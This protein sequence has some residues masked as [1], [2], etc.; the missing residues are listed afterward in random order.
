MGSLTVAHCTPD[1]KDCKDPATMATYL[2]KKVKLNGVFK[3]FQKE[4][5]INEKWIVVGTYYMIDVTNATI[6]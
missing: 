5:Y 1:F 3:E 2:D 4:Q 6:I